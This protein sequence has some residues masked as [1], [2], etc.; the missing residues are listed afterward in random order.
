ML[1]LSFALD[2]SAYPCLGI[3]LLFTA[4]PRRRLSLL[5]HAIL[6]RRLSEPRGAV[7]QQCEADPWHLS[8]G[9]APDDPLVCLVKR[10]EIVA[11]S[12]ILDT[13]PDIISRVDFE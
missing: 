12:G 3:T 5:R 10:L 8:A 4:L 11:V 6:C 1:C 2:C 7:S 13:E 9:Y